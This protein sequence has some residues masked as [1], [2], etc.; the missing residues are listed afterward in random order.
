MLFSPKLANEAARR[1]VFVS[2][3]V[4]F[5]QIGRGESKREREEGV[6]GFEPDAES[7]GV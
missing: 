5:F 2:R 6:S 7:V 1:N 4:L 3:I